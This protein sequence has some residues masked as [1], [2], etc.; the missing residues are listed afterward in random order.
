[1]NAASMTAEPGL[2]MIPIRSNMDRPIFGWDLND[3]GCNPDEY[4]YG[5]SRH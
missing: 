2:R 3:S 1:M 5:P 4:T